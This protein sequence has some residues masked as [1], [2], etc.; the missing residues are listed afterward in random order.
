M[1]ERTGLDWQEARSE[2]GG[3]RWEAVLES[4]VQEMLDGGLWG[5]PSFRVSGGDAEPF[6]CWG[7]DRLWRVETEI[8]K[9]A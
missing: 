1:I 8:A 5:V 3:S 6:F 4:N 9:R 7:Q 2:L